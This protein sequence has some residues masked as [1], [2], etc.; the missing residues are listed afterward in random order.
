MR[1][2]T[3]PIVENME[4]YHRQLGEIFSLIGGGILVVVVLA[5][6][7][8]LGYWL[9][10]KVHMARLEYTV[11]KQ[12]VKRGGAIMHL[13]LAEGVSLKDLTATRTEVR[14][15]PPAWLDDRPVDGFWLDEQKQCLRIV[16]SYVEA[17]HDPQYL[18]VL[19]DQT[20]QRDPEVRYMT[21]AEIW[22]AFGID[23]DDFPASNFDPSTMPRPRIYQPT[24]KEETEASAPEG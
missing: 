16:P 6:F 3:K 10:T 7:V 2:K 21:G 20:G 14:E 24:T 15:V 17:G 19:E 5:I 4:H 8:M 11:A 1:F 18:V 23:I 13:M 22:D 9:L 12:I